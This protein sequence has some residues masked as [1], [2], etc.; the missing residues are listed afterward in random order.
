MIYR[1]LPPPPALGQFV[2]YCWT[3][4]SHAGDE[5]QAFRTMA[6]ASPGIIFQ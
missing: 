6:D 1:L 2:Q 4:E 3:L 5:A